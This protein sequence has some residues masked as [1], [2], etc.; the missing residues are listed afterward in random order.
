MKI[1]RR[2]VFCVLFLLVLGTVLGGEAKPCAFGVVTDI[3]Y[4][5]KMTRYARHYRESLRKTTE[6]VAEFNA[7]S[8][9]F[10]IEL[11]DLMDGY[12]N[13]TD[14]SLRDLDAVL[15]ILGALRAPLYFVMGNHCVNGGREKVMAR[16]KLEKSYYDFTRPAAPGWRFIV[17][18]G[19]LAGYGVPGAKQT[20]WL[21]TRL[22]D[23]GKAGQRVLL[24]CHFPL[25]QPEGRDHRMKDKDVEPIV[26]ILKEYSCVAAWFSGHD[27][28][29][30]Y[31]E[32]D[33]IHYMNFKGMVE[34]VSNAYAV[35][36]LDGDQM[37]IK[38]FGNEP[39]R[40]LKICPLKK[41]VPK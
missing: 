36:T 40:E 23:A 39:S 13:D 11:G 15:P 30:G 33:G 5:D 31:V 7:R 29:G 34:A 1:A 10:V 6:C 4:G 26:A 12:Q 32:R 28:R 41:E 21:K 37:K 22:A 16:L 14:H 2:Q 18:D 27:H 17:L 35:V 25:L 38:G 19:T 9:D 20:D 24:F 8:L 3:Q